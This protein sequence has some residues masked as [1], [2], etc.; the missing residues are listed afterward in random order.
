MSRYQEKR[1]KLRRPFHYDARISTEP[2][3]PQIKCRITDVSKNGAHIVLERD[4]ELTAKFV[5]LFSPIGYPRR[6]CNLIWRNGT[7][8]GVRFTEK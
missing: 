6:N 2:N 1:L 5:L 3:A 4:Q 7:E 8:V